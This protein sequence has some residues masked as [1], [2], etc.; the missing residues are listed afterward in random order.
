[1]IPHYFCV[2]L[3][4]A[5]QCRLTQEP[6]SSGCPADFGGK[7]R[8]IERRGGWTASGRVAKCPGSGR[9][10]FPYQRWRAGAELPAWSPGAGRGAGGGATWGDAGAPPR[11]RLPGLLTRPRA[12]SKASA[13]A[14]SSA[15][16][17][18][19]FPVCVLCLATRPFAWPRHEAYHKP[20]REAAGPEGHGQPPAYQ[21][22]PSHHGGRIRSELGRWAATPGAGTSAPCGAAQCHHGGGA[23]AGVGGADSWWCAPR[24][25]RPEDPSRRAGPQPAS[26]PWG[27]ALCAL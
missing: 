18:L 13:A 27:P 9:P 15:A 16:V 25:S 21:L 2:W 6:G 14:C 10:Q 17:R 8:G 11:A 26:V 1:M 20:D 3:I 4:P 22:H 7:E 12:A 24:R 19:S 5:G 23:G